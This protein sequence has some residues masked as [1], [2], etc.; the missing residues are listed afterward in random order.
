MRVAAEDIVLVFNTAEVWADRDVLH[1]TFIDGG[2]I[3]RIP[4]AG[5]LLPDDFTGWRCEID[6]HVGAVQFTN[7]IIHVCPTLGIGLFI[8]YDGQDIYLPI[9]TK[10]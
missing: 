9:L 4:R 6:I 8:T 2:I 1:C 3:S 10:E 7:H 5:I